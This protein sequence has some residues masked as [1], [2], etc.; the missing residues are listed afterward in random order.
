MIIEETELIL[1]VMGRS[2]DM[3]ATTPKPGMTPIKVPRSTP[4]K[5][6]SK[7]AGIK[8]TEKPYKT[9]LRISTLKSQK[10]NRKKQ[11]QPN[12]EQYIRGHRDETCRC[13]CKPPS[14]FHHHF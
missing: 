13:R 8:L 2:K 6:D 10:P 11:F 3:A 12:L 9:L 14:F 4:I 1:N 7:L 5:Q